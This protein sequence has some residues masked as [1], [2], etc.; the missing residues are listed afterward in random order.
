[1]SYYIDW[2]NKNIKKY[3]TFDLDWPKS[4]TTTEKTE[5][6]DSDDYTETTTSTKSWSWITTLPRT[7]STWSTYFYDFTA[8]N[9]STF[10]TLP[11]PYNRTTTVW[12]FGTLSTSTLST[13]QSHINFR[14]I[15]ESKFFFV[16]IY[17]LCALVLAG[18]ISCL[19]SIFCKKEAKNVFSEPTL[20]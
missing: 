7:T 3:E 19:K 16:L 14:S 11:T 20:V 8:Q 2:I 17:V 10:S 1:M 9:T 13:P 18:F 6:D 15:Y 4:S 5:F 12:W